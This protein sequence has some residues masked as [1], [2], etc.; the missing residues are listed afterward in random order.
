LTRTL[1]LAA[2]GK[3]VSHPGGRHDSD[4]LVA[5]ADFAAS[6]WVSDMDLAW[7]VCERSGLS[8]LP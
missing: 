5:S 6:Q 7:D 1:Y 3:C 4:K 8:R 2:L